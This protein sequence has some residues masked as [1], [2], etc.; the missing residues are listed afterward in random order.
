[1][2]LSALPVRRFGSCQDGTL[3]PISLA[4]DV[5]AGS[6]CQAVLTV[7]GL[8]AL[9]SAHAMA[10]IVTKIGAFISRGSPVRR[11]G[12]RPPRTILKR[13]SLQGAKNPER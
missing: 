11:S 3:S 4:I 12:R 10:L 2:L 1:M 13:R 5:A 7:L 6:L 9:L 8:S